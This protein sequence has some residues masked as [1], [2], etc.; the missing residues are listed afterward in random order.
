MSQN[1][2]PE[3]QTL[4]RFTALAQGGYY[5]LSGIWP[6]LHL[7]SFLAVT[8]MKTDLWL[9]QTVGALIAVSGLVFIL[10]A[11]SRRITFEILVLGLGQAFALGFVDIFFVT[12]GRVPPV[13]LLDAAAECFL[14]ILWLLAT[15][16]TW[17]APMDA[18]IVRRI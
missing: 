2:S 7:P 11:T 4:L 5:F 14:M 6:L 16:R 12:V 8:G 13:Y 17:R 3:L 1:R 9:V 15:T 10:A 18:G